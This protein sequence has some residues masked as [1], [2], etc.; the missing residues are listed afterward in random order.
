MARNPNFGYKWQHPDMTL[1]VDWDVKRQFKWA[2]F[3]QKLL[4]KWLATRLGGTSRSF[5]GS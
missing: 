4:H 5:I 3:I 1:V 2:T